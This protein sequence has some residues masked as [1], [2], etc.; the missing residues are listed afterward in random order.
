MPRANNTA[1]VEDNA[2]KNEKV[3]IFNSSEN[4]TKK[5][6]L[7]E[8]RI[9]KTTAETIKVKEGYK[10]FLY[11]VAELGTAIQKGLLPLTEETMGEV[12][13]NTEQFTMTEKGFV[14][15]DGGKTVVVVCDAKEYERLIDERAKNWTADNI[16]KRSVKIK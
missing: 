2:V 13:C 1:P 10:I 3:D 16:K 9:G 4:T 12:L 15:S 5:L 6:K 14:T 8:L 11:P 7:P